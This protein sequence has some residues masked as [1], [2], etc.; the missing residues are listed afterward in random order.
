MADDKGNVGSADRRTVAS[1]EPY[2]V[3]YFAG[4]HGISPQ[5]ARDLIAQH[6]NDRAALDAAAGALKP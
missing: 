4:K 5:Q 2:E 6:G 1:D 3:E